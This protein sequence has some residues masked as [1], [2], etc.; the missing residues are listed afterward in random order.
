M[1][2]PM[3]AI[4][5]GGKSRRMG[6]HK[7]LLPIPEGSGPIVEALVD[8]A[9]EAGF[10]PV[11]VGEATA[12]AHLAVGVTRIG[13]EPRNA[14]PLGGLRAALRHA[15]RTGRT[16]VVAIACDMPYVSPKA[17]GEV[18]ALQSDAP[19]VA[20]R[21]GPDAPWEP[22]L[23]RYDATRLS[24]VLDSAVFSGVRSFQRLFA[25]IEVAALPLTPAV[26]RALDDWDTPEDLTR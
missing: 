22:M 3:L 7:G 14:G 9:R 8:R 15:V 18:G 20:A 5:V 16:H 13:D 25:T 26:A 24:D 17:L 4:F 23:A 21:R 11:L 12:Y 10:E 2:A 6:Q 1:T 19:V